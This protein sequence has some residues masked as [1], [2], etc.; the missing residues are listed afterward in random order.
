VNPYGFLSVIPGDL[1]DV[2]TEL[3][4][5]QRF[6][7]FAK[8]TCDALR[9]HPDVAMD[10]SGRLADAGLESLSRSLQVLSERTRYPS[11]NKEH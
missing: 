7:R 6:L 4:T 3:T 9:N 1:T 2:P 11:T 10:L 5:E 8:A